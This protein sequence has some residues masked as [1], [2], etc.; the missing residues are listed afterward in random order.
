[1]LAG[2]EK[3][4]SV[5]SVDTSEFVVQAY[6]TNLPN[7][8]DS[9]QIVTRNH[10][11]FQEAC[12]LILE[13]RIGPVSEWLFPEFSICYYPEDIAALLLEEATQSRIYAYLFSPTNREFIDLLICE[14][15]ADHHSKATMTADNN[16]MR[17][18]SVSR[19]EQVMVYCIENQDKKW[20]QC[21]KQAMKLL[22]EDWDNDPLG[23]FA[24]WATGPQ[25]AIGGAIGCGIKEIVK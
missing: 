19:N 10:P 11:V 8:I 17:M 14:W 21:M 25:C 4:T 5:S 23:T 3:E 22:Y 2:C 7:S 12:K 24:C 16:L 13:K 18:F 6:Q 1:V 15:E 20:G 9:V